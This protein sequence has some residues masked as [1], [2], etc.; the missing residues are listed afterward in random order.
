MIDSRTP[1][2][3]LD[4]PKQFHDSRSRAA[5]VASGFGLSIVRASGVSIFIG[6]YAVVGLPS[7]RITG[8]AARCSCYIEMLL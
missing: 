5:A 4:E 6:E 2:V 3:A 8:V 1:G 7:A